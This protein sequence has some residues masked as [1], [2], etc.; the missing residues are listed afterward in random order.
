[1]QVNFSQH[2]HMQAPLHHYRLLLQEMNLSESEINDR[3]REVGGE[4]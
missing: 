4:E 2:P 3:L 1:M